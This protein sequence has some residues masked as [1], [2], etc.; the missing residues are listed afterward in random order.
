M[1][2]SAMNPA[3]WAMASGR[4][5]SSAASRSASAPASTVT[6]A[7]KIATDSARASTST[8][9]GAATSSQPRSREVI[10]TCPPPPG[11]HGATSAGSSA[12]SKTSSHRPRC[13]S[14]AST[15]ARIASV[16]AWNASQRQAEG[17]DLVPDQP[18]LLGVDPPGQVVGPGEP[19]RV[20]GRQLGLAHPAHPVQRLHHRRVP[21][22]QPLPHLSQQIV[23]AGE[24]R[25][26]RRECSTPA[27]PPARRTAV[28]TSA[29]GTRPRAAATNNARTGSARPSAPPSSTAVS[30]R[31]VRLMPRSRS[32]TDRGLR[33]A[34]F[35]SSSCVSR[36]SARSCRSNPANPSAGCSAMV[37]V[38]PPQALIPP[39]RN[40]A[41]R[42][43][44]YAQ[45][46]PGPATCTISRYP[47]ANGKC[48]CPPRTRRRR[49]CNA[50]S[51][52]TAPRASR[53]RTPPSE[54]KYPA[55]AD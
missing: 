5:P 13:R 17:G 6:R 3:A 2:V 31:A 10:S 35:A 32:L 37:P 24:P 18:A 29:A 38:S 15:A 46:Y 42:G 23:A 14:S 12:L 53:Q 9:T 16:P 1:P 52:A 21:G 26:T 8:S 50:R 55:P 27:A 34:A 54:V 39:H 45:H 51:R 11:S 48:G 19:V 4:S 49:I 25:I 7:C 33:P 44:T 20:L 36:A 30:L 47:Y 40:P 28:S 41:G 43:R 22:Q